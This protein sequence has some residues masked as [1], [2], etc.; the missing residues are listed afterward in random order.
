MKHLS[1]GEAEKG[2]AAVGEEI[3]RQLRAGGDQS[4]IVTQED[5]APKSKTSHEG[6]TSTKVEGGTAEYQVRSQN[7]EG[8]SRKPEAG[9]Q[10]SDSEAKGREAEPTDSAAGEAG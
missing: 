2:I 7:D 1:E 10:E 6:T 4:T 9:S 3:G 5:E 8:R